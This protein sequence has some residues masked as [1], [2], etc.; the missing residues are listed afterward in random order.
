MK[1][2]AILGQRKAASRAL[3]PGVRSY[4]EDAHTLFVRNEWLL[5]EPTRHC[6]EDDVGNTRMPHGA[7]FRPPDVHRERVYPPAGTELPSLRVA[8]LGEVHDHC[9]DYPSDAYGQD[10]CA[11]IHASRVTLNQLF[12]WF[13]TA[14][15]ARVCSLEGTAMRPAA[16]SH[17]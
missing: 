8:I 4:V 15:T 7:L 1:H 5:D 12:S 10:N 14:H 6:E 9:R 17:P 16:P 13:D 2:P 11:V 3:L